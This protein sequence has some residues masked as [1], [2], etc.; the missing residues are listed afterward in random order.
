MCGAAIARGVHGSEEFALMGTV[1]CSSILCCLQLIQCVWL[2]ILT[3]ASKDILL[4]TV[5]MSQIHLWNRTIPLQLAC[6]GKAKTVSSN[7]FAGT[8]Q[9]IKS[10]KLALSYILSTGSVMYAEYAELFFHSENLVC[11][12]VG[13]STAHW[14]C[15]FCGSPGKTE[16]GINPARNTPYCPH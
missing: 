9:C 16:T 4:I 8:H 7:S 6:Q 2:E 5:K 15:N 14:I 13:S 3:T 10:L 12:G 11:A 1:L